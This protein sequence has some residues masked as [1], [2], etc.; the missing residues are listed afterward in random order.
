MTARRTHH[1]V[2]GLEI[3]ES[4]HIQGPPDAP[5]TLIEYGDYQCPFCGEA[6]PTIKQLQQEVGDGMRFVFR[7][8]PLT[9]V[10]PYAEV[11]AEAAEAAGGQG[12]F[13]EMHD[14]LYEHQDEL[15][16]EQLIAHAA[17][18]GLDIQLFTQD[19][20]KHAYLEKV[21]EDFM[22]GLRSGVN[23][24]PTFFINGVRHDGAYDFDTLLDAIE[25]HLKK[26]AA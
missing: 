13:W 3:K 1:N 18:L 7:N 19:L 5:V 21:R 20:I 11:A 4:D 8:F 24:T 15:R 2:P 16:P 17:R 26:R 22:S 9:S 25:A 6:Y 23:G 10:H 12:K 14:T